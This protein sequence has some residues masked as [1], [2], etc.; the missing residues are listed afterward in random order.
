[1]AHCPRQ[2]LPAAGLGSGVQA[3]GPRETWFAAAN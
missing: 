3:E 2:S 1:M